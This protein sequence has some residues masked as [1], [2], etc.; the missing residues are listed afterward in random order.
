VASSEAAASPVA[1]EALKGGARID[2]GIHR[3][4]FRSPGKVE[5]VGATIT[6]ITRAGSLASVAAQLERWQTGLIADPIR[7]DLID[8]NARLDV[9]ARSLARMTTR[10]KGRG[11]SGMVA[12]AIAVLISRVDCEARNQR[13]VPTMIRQRLE[14]HRQI[15]VFPHD[16]RRPIRHI[17][18]VGNIDP[19]YSFWKTLRCGRAGSAHRRER[20]RGEHRIEDRQCDGGAKSA[21]KRAPRYLPGGT[22]GSA[23]IMINGEA[24]DFNP[25]SGNS[26]VAQSMWGGLYARQATAVSFIAYEIGRVRRCGK[27]NA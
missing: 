15:V 3:L 11:R 23:A 1:K 17:F 16:F 14:N 20:L 10:Q 25:L 21:K 5:L 19:S 22:H 4:R 27:R 8:R 24:I 18:T 9:G 6:R 26:S 2:L 13:K 12:A 7:G